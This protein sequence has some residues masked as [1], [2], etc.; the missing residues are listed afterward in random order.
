MKTGE[1]VYPKQRKRRKT[2]ATGISNERVNS[3]R[4]KMKTSLRKLRDAQ[5]SR[6]EGGER[7]RLIL[8]E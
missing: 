6:V 8:G 1:W 4:R 5:F 2:N 7:E 3:V